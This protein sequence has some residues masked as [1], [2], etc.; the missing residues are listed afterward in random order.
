M[1]TDIPGG[2][3]TG[4]LRHKSLERCQYMGLPSEDHTYSEYRQKIVSSVL[5]RKIERIVPNNSY[6]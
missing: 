5:V 3:Q 4:H 1:I 6:Q 2:F